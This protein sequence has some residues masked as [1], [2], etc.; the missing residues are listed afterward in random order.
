MRW[1]TKSN[2]ATRIKDMSENATRT[3]SWAANNMPTMGARAK[4]VAEPAAGNAQRIAAPNAGSRIAR[5]ESYS[6]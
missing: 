2:S 1:R 4:E 5:R 6:T 3:P